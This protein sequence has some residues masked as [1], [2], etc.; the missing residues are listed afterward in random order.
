MRPDILF[1]LF[2]PL[3]S[4][5]GVGVKLTPL[6][7]KLC[8]DKIIDILFHLPIGV[9]D[10]TYMPLLKHAQKGKIA[11]LKLN[12]IEHIKPAL[13]G[14]PYRVICS[15]GSDEITLTFFNARNDYLNRTLPIDKTVIVS[16]NLERFGRGWSMSH[17]DFIVKEN[18]ID[19]IPKYEPVYALTEGI[20]RKRIYNTVAQALPHLP[21]MPEWINSDLLKRENWKS[22]KEEI[23][24]AHNPTNIDDLENNKRLAYDE[25]LANQLALAI[26]R[27]HHH[28]KNGRSFKGTGKLQKK[29]IEN[30]PFTLTNGQKEIIKEISNDIKSDKRMLR[31][32]QGDVG[33]GKTII[34]LIIMLQIVESGSQAALMAPTE[35]LARQ[36]FETLK[37]L[38][39]PVGVSIDILLGK[40]RGKQRK[41]TLEK[42]ANGEISIIV[43]THALFQKDVVFYD[44]ALAVMDEQ[45]R[46]GVEQR[47]KLTNKGKGTD[48]L[49]MTATPIPRT[50]TLTAYGDMDVSRLTEKPAGRKAIETRTIDINRLNEVIAG[51]DRQIK[52]GAQ[53]YWVCPLI[54]ESEKIDLA[55][56][57]E[58][59]KILSKY[60]GA[61]KIGLI[62][63]KISLDEK[64]KIMNE[65]KSGKIK[66]LV[67]TT[68]IEVGVDVTNAT[69][70]IIE[71]AERFGLS[72]LHQLRG[73][74]GRGEKNSTCL[75]LY[76]APLS[77]TAIS[78]LKIMRETEDGFMIAE[79]DLR[80][81]GGGELLG[82]KQSGL[83]EY[84]IADL[85]KDNRLLHIANKDS[86]NLINADPLLKSKRGGNLRILLYLFNKD[87]SVK[88]FRSG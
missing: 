70:M 57:T 51:I 50:L 59:F 48:I 82:T 11:T 12:V 55:A 36:H 9:I 67:A 83:P 42:L 49:A 16:G 71:H 63:G 78:R 25:L 68:V 14:K 75:L 3:R 77:E 28:K 74:V 17:P 23:I 30:L 21:D 61:E 87:A 18:K 65:F 46:F 38:L 47:L 64:E 44:L 34:A 1:S 69:L 19:E 86:Q 45:H 85:F 66:I 35:I 52:K 31:L 80:L 43:G 5:K 40:S 79:E 33:A 4:L 29:L 37:T 32:L 76:Q 7:S 72:Q 10:R 73:R 88:L 84:K 53:A 81:R 15:D 26:I 13:K 27:Y 58:R 20:T 2:A 24:K 56:A 62:H 39:K 41:E 6:F 22:W 8:G 60:F 54:E